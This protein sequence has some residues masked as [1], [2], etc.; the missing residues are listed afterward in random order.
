MK[1]EVEQYIA[2]DLKEKLVFLVGPRQV[3]KTWLASDMQKRARSPRYLNYDQEQDRKVMKQYAWGRADLLVLDEVHKM[4]GWKN[5]VKGVFD[6]RPPNMQLL[7]TGSATLDAHRH[8]GDSLAGRYFVHHLLPLTLYE[9][10]AT[11]GS[12]DALR[13]FER[14]GFPY[15]YLTETVDKAERWREMY[16]DSVVREDA[17]TIQG[18]DNFYAFKSIFQLLRLQVGSPVSYS[19]I[20]QNIGISPHT[21]K[22][23]IAILE[24][25]YVVFRVQPYTHKIARSILKEPKLY[26][27]DTGLVSDRGARFENM[28][29]LELYAY[30]RRIKDRKGKGVTLA[31]LSTK[32]GHEVDFALINKK[33]ELIHAIEA[34][35]SDSTPTKALKYF[36]EK[37]SVPGTQVV[38]TDTQTYAPTQHI[39]IR[40]IERFVQDVLI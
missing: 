10:V 16:V 35:M 5:Y 31:S 24:A 11:T 13:L 7:V 3:G 25:L 1:R 18:I 23:Y 9:Q 6:T 2:E 28:L 30:T 38:F 4:R 36:T 8:A 14:G 17:I 39:H 22:K 21:V 20:A 27:F 26:F 33:N 12:S 19:S 34:K 15:P 29:A 37:Y 32:E 40:S